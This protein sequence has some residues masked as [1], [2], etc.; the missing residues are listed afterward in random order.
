MTL[1]ATA[2]APKSSPIRTATMTTTVMTHARVRREPD[3]PLMLRVV[4]C[5]IV[6][7]SSA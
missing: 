3:L 5:V 2:L 6:A 1:S 4:V 7:A